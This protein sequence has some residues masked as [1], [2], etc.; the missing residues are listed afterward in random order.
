MGISYRKRIKIGDDTYLNISK[1]GISVSKK[2]GKT[3]INSKGT[4]TISLGNGMTYR[5]STKTNKKKKSNCISETWRAGNNRIYYYLLSCLF[6]LNF[7]VK[8]IDIY[9]N[10]C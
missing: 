6:I 5:T 4:T 3:T 9:V 10:L 2:V 1:S 7:L 8:I